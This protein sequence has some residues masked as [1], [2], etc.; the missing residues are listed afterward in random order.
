MAEYELT[1]TPINVPQ[2]AKSA[3]APN[4]ELQLRG[5]NPDL[6]SGLVLAGANRGSKS[7]TSTDPPSPPA[8]DGIMTALEVASLDLQGVE[9]VALSACESGYGSRF[10]P[11]TPITLHAG[12]QGAIVSYGYG[13]GTTAETDGNSFGAATGT[14]T[15]PWTV[16]DGGGL[17]AFVG[18]GRFSGSGVGIQFPNNIDS[19][20]ANRYAAGTFA[21][22][23]VPEP[24]TFV[25]AVLAVL[26]LGLFRRV[27]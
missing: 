26:M 3:T 27:S 13:N 7:E 20:P 16:N 19:G 5:Y 24:S 25:L 12:F 1:R 10:L 22:S 21:F 18:S 14:P 15:F 8:D 17:I 11:I 6:L 9:L 23:A 4:Q 2:P